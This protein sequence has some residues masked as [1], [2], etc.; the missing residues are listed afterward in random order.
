MV[1]GEPKIPAGSGRVAVVVVRC[2]LKR[3]GRGPSDR[4][5]RWLVCWLALDAKGAGA[6]AGATWLGVGEALQWAGR[7]CCGF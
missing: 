1:G 4:S 2:G 7:V 3:E 6:G 5:R